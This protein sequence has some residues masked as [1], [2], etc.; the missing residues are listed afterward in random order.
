ML[1]IDIDSA[2]A[3]LEALEKTVRETSERLVAGVAFKYGKDSRE[4]EM[5]GGGRKSDRICKA[6]LTRLKANREEIAPTPQMASGL[7]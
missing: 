1:L 2:K 4:Y 5:A 3:T 7:S 6:T